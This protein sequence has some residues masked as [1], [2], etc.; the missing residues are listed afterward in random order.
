MA[1]ARFRASWA[2]ALSP[3]LSAALTV[4]IADLNLSLVA[5]LFALRLR[6]CLIAL[7]A[8]LVLGINKY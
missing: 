5:M 7:E 3:E 4:L 6:D 1:K 8:D 2:L